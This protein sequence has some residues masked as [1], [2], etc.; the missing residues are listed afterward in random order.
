MVHPYYILPTLHI[1]T[2]PQHIFYADYILH[3][4]IHIFDHALL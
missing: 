3:L 1:F 4:H 2:T